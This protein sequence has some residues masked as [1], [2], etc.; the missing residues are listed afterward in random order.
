MPKRI[1]PRPEDGPLLEAVARALRGFIDSQNH[2]GKRL[3]QKEL[4]AQ[5]GVSPSM[6]TNLVN[7]L[8]HSK[9]GSKRQRDVS[10]QLLLRALQAGIPIDYNELQFAAVSSRPQQIAF[11]FDGSLPCEETPGGVAVRVERKGPSFSPVRVQ[12]KVAG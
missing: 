10:G 12:I 6:I 2:Q 4:A 7:L 1:T 5:L 3:N 8:D 11:V 9:N